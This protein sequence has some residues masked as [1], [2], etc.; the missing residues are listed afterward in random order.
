MFLCAFEVR[1]ALQHD[2]RNRCD[3]YW[4]AKHERAKDSKSPAAV[5]DRLGLSRD[6]LT[7]SA[8][9]HLNAAPHLRR[10][11]TKA[12]AKHLASSVWSATERHLFCDASGR[13]H[14]RMHI[15]RWSDFAQLPGQARS[16]IRTN[17]W[18]TFR[19][20]GSLT[21]HRATY[22]TREGDFV[23]PPRLHQVEG[24]AWWNYDGPL[25]LVFSGLSNGTLV[26]PMRLPTAP[27]NQAC[28]EHYLVDPSKWHKIDL[29]RH[30]DP[31]ADGGWRYEAHLMALVAP[32]VSLAVAQ[33]RTETA[34]ATADRQVGIDVNV[35]NITVAS[36]VQGRDVRITRVVRDET[37][38]EADR[39]RSR[40]ER[41]QQRDLDRSR[42][43][44]N[45][46]QYQLSK[47]QEKRERRRA[48][49]GLPPQDVTP[50]GSRKSTSNGKPLQSFR[51]D[52][53]SKTYRRGRLSLAADA[54]SAAQARRDRA[55]LVA[56]DLVHEHGYVPV[57]EDC[58]I[59]A[60]SRAWGRALA[61]F[62][63]GMLISAIE[64]E[65][66]AVAHI[67]QSSIALTRASTRTTAMSQ[68]CP[69]G[70]RVS[71]TLAVRVHVC[72]TCGLRGDRDAVSAVLAA[73][74]TFKNRTQPSTAS[75]DYDASRAALD[76]VASA[77][78]RTL[79][80]W[81]GSPSES[82]ALTARDGTSVARHEVDTRRR[83]RGG[84]AKRGRASRST[85]N[86]TGASQTKSERMRM[87]VHMTIDG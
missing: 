30:P 11:V 87:R 35:S 39:R 47:R 16:H 56:G 65:A 80:G 57:V 7:Q 32:Y 53:L 20:H 55:R 48:D 22:T 49:A 66:A 64:R 51:R 54:G 18:R 86:E 46:A 83:R 81:Q 84:S 33:R 59:S 79:M 26:L 76:E 29:V 21:S 27:S 44:T 50:A 58:A 45:S 3:A 40:R 12:L 23:Q 31:N 43:A 61:A 62:T 9:G 75:V 60:W 17:D 10:F 1:R 67:V 78:S 85:P 69:C 6:G 13:R 71:K 24:D 37:R 25:V 68:H 19:L 14:G 77:L 52:E 74:V 2:A 41:R 4:A 8:Y 34:I 28:L 42:R 5:R 72:P 82:N 63:P 36:H 15:G 73:F 70:A 38:Q